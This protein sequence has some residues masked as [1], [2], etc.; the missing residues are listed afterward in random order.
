MRLGAAKLSIHT[1]FIVRQRVR[2][3]HGKK[4]AKTGKTSKA[5]KAKKVTSAEPRPR[6]TIFRAK[7]PMSWALN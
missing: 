5:S 6:P 7:P 2:E 1:K 4:T 3:T